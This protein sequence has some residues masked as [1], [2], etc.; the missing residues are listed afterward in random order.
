MDDVKRTVRLAEK[1]F[2]E[3]CL[4]LFKLGFRSGLKIWEYYL[5]TITVLPVWKFKIYYGTDNFKTIH[6]TWGKYLKCVRENIF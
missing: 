4:G 3:K 5:G 1:V 2:D 6:H